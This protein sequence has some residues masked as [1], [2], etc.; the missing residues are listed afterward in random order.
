[1]TDPRDSAS[2]ERATEAES[3]DEVAAV[4]TA[5]VVAEAI[6]LA[7]CGAIELG[8]ERRAI[9]A[10]HSSFDAP[11]AC[12]TGDASS[13]DTASIELVSEHVGGLR[14][15]LRSV[16]GWPD[17]DGWLDADGWPAID[18]ITIE[19]A[20]DD[21][22][23][24]RCEDRPIVAVEV[25]RPAAATCTVIELVTRAVAP[26]LVDLLVR[27]RSP[28]DRTSP[29]GSGGATVEPDLERHMDEWLR[30]VQL[31]PLTGRER[32]VLLLLVQGHRLS[33]V[34]STLFLSQHT[35]RN[36]L[37]RIFAKLGIHSQAELVSRFRNESR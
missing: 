3:V 31:S 10:A 30:T 28:G 1:M 29:E 21:R 36:H 6:R 15:R 27:D 20:A 26:A 19:R 5:E 12:C 34:A 11:A 2:N 22:R 23:V 35:V 14:V 9:E 17:T 13:E 37:K 24:V 25:T 16:V 4:A 32:E 33:T 7:L 8:R 18:R